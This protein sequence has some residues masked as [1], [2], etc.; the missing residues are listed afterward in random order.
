LRKTPHYFFC[1]KIINYFSPHFL[2]QHIAENFT[3]IYTM[4]TFGGAWVT[5]LHGFL[6]EVDEDYL[7]VHNR[8]GL[9]DRLSHPHGVTL[10]LPPAA[11]RK[12]IVDEYN[13]CSSDKAAC[14]IKNKLMSLIIP[15]GVSDKDWA[16]LQKAGF[17]VNAVGNQVAIKEK[18][19]KTITLEGDA[20]AEPT[21]ESSFFRC[22]REGVTDSV[23]F[24]Y[25]ISKMPADGKPTETKMRS[26][27]AEPVG[28]GADVANETSVETWFCNALK[29]FGRLMAEGNSGAH[30]YV[31]QIMMKWYSIVM[32]KNAAAVPESR[33]LEIVM[34]APPT[35]SGTL[36]ASM[37]MWALLWLVMRPDAPNLSSLSSEEFQALTAEINVSN[38][39]ET[40]NLQRVSAFRAN[41]LCGES[42]DSTEKMAE[43]YAAL[44]AVNEEMKAALGNAANISDACIVIGGSIKKFFASTSKR[45]NDA[46][47]R[48]PK[49]VDTLFV[50]LVLMS[51]MRIIANEHTNK[52]TWEA[53]RDGR[54]APEF[55]LL[56]AR[57]TLYPISLSNGNLSDEW[58]KVLKTINFDAL[59][60]TP[61]GTVQG[62]NAVAPSLALV[63][64]MR[65]WS[66]FG[67]GDLDALVSAVNDGSA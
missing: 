67:G 60:A 40:Q 1:G 6:E 23:Y 63:N 32:N 16:V 9:G 34:A 17:Y 27:L 13:K 14:A 58:L 66:T 25:D 53:L 5:D 15:A 11:A 65:A 31:S 49:A 18:S 3:H 39:N 57:S 2:P 50:S 55:A 48:N 51:D 21:K 64:A 43:R 19:G 37:Q 7:R 35:E 4:A 59:I 26:L 41:F 56:C 33:A 10:L 8:V 24:V 38:A 61:P 42:D 36:S 30:S 62:G 44:Q 54:C 47:A 12:A 46:L 29:E 22:N 20:K 52:A 45:M 28:G